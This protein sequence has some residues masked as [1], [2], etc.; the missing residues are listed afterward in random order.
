[1]GKHED[2]E[3]RGVHLQ[4]QLIVPEAAMIP[5]ACK[6]ASYG[7]SN[8]LLRISCALPEIIWKMG[9]CMDAMNHQ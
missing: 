1:M 9:P 6:G 8:T 2:I 4:K 7:R 5:A 3:N